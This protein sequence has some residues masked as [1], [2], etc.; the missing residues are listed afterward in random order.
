MV[1]KGLDVRVREHVAYSF[2][3]QVSNQTADTIVGP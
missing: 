1:A 3:D 2:I